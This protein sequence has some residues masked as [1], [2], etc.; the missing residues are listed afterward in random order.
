MTKKKKIIVTTIDNC[1]YNNMHTHVIRAWYLGRN[2][3]SE[4]SY[5]RATWFRG[6]K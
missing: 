3:D 1:P 4:K 2:Q 5:R 6:A